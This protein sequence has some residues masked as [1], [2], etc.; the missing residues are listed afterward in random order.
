VDGR[1]WRGRIPGAELIER[2]DRYRYLVD[3]SAAVAD[4]LAIAA[5]DGDVT[6]FAFEPPGLSD[7][8]RAAVKQ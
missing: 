3:R 1:P 6:R 5:E 4:L 2:N 8:F 7:L